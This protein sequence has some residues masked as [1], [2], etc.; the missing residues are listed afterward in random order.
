MVLVF[1]PIPVEVRNFLIINVRLW[2]QI[3]SKKLVDAII[4]WNVFTGVFIRYYLMCESEPVILSAI[5][6]LLTIIILLFLYLLSLKICLWELTELIQ[7]FT[8]QNNSSIS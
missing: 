8:R 5:I 6:I 2:Y 7:V 4:C 3:F 1:D